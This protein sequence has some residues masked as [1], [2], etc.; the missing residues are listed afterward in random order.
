MHHPTQCVPCTGRSLY[1]SGAADP[2]SHL[3]FACRQSLYAVH[4]PAPQSTITPF[5]GNHTT[6]FRGFTPPFTSVHGPTRYDMSIDRTL[7]A[8]VQSSNLACWTPFSSQTRLLSIS[9]PLRP[10]LSQA[11]LEGTIPYLPINSSTGN[12]SVTLPVTFTVQ[13]GPDHPLHSPL[14]QTPDTGLELMHR[15]AFVFDSL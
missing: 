13:T 10:R 6:L 11:L 14:P 2:V 3:C 8:Y 7:P 12:F 9:P 5:A 4:N 1:C 15:I